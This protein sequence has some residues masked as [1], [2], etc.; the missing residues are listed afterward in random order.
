MKK[1]PKTFYNRDTITVAQ[2]LLGK[3]LI[4]NCD[5]EEYV[6][7][8]T[9]TEVYV[10]FDDKASHAFKGK[11]KRNYPMFEAAGI[12]YIYMI[13][14]MYYC[15]NIVTEKEGFPAAV[16]IRALEP[17]VVSHPDPE[18]SEGKGSLKIL[19]PT[20]CRSQNNIKFTNGPGKLCR[21]MQIDRNLNGADLIKSKELYIA[22]PPKKEKIEIIKSKRVGVGYAGPYAHYHWRFYIKN[23]SYVSK[24]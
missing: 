14:G 3:F 20:V 12:A 13:Y 8:I 23:N 5:G 9:E 2:E 6:G 22:S 24:K 7:M 10:G 19:P 15:L 1:L 16:L 18:R 21:W 4:H 11:T 17:L